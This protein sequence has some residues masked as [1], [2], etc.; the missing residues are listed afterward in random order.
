MFFLKW[1][2]YFVHFLESVC[3]ISKS[4]KLSLSS[5]FQLVFCEKTSEF[6]SQLRQSHKWFSLEQPS[7]FYM[8]Q[9]CFIYTYCFVTKNT[10]KIGTWRLTCNFYCFVKDLHKC[11]W[12]ACLP[13]FL[14]P[15]LS[16]S[17]F[18]YKCVAMK[19]MTTSTVWR[20]NLDLINPIEGPQN[21]QEFAD[22]ILRL[23]ALCLLSFSFS[24]LVTTH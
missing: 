23:T 21:P 8:Q 15:S 11:H 12:P 17:S 7:Y 20:H 24:S 18:C 10:K 2:A 22:H 9:K 6:S 3:Q 4:E 1:K 16:P 5:L 13:A 19:K 14:P